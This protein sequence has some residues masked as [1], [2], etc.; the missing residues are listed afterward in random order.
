MK[1][2]QTGFT[3][4]ELVAALAISSFVIVGLQGMIESTLED[5]KSQQA[6]AFQNRVAQGL[7]KFV[8]DTTWNAFIKANA[9]TTVPVKVTTA[10]LVA[11]NFLPAGTQ[12]INAYG[13]TACGLIYYDSAAGKIN[14]LLTTEG[15]TA[16]GEKQLGYVS[17]NAGDGAG[18]ISSVSPTLA[19]GAFGGWQTTLSTWTDATAAKNCTGTPAAAGHL[20]TQQ[21]FD[22][23]G[24]LVSDFLYRNSIAGRPDLNTMNTPIIMAPATV[25]TADA[26]CATQGAIA[27]EVA[28][29]VVSCVDTGGGVLLWKI[30]G[31]STY[32]SDPVAGYNNLP[33]CNAAAAW[34][35]RVVQTPTT[36]TG[37]RAYTCDGAT[38][39]ALAV[40]DTGSITISGS[41]TINKLAGNLQVTA[42]AVEGAACVGD[43]RI[44]ASTTTSGLI[45]SCQSGVWGKQARTAATYSG[46]VIPNQCWAG[47]MDWANSICA[48]GQWIS[49][50]FPQPFL[51]PPSI[52][53]VVEGINYTTSPCM[54]GGTDGTTSSAAYIT[55]T[56]AWIYAGAS[57]IPTNC[58]AASGGFGQV[59][60]KWIAV[61]VQ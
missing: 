36:G 34:Q 20:A 32:W 45:L 60:V 10:N 50:T 57:P 31:G 21:F 55:T 11:G 24:A 13:Q 22:A 54:M 38:W 47:W 40:D 12:A 26:V 27:R 33:A 43:G 6:G 3:L 25:Q 44:A 28:G 39:K 4:L 2:R 58:G 41:A 17:A 7:Q 18:Y 61:G 29:K 8:S 19:K 30:A 16:I 37:P 59:S 52:A 35:T 15:G 1:I 14:A 23:S 42:T 53:V 46:S 9:T 5:S 51:V 49:I 56:D 48:A